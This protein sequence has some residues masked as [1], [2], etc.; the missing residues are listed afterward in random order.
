MDDHADTYILD[1]AIH[2]FL[3]DAGKMMPGW[4]LEALLYKDDE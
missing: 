3:K 4:F 2:R 1:E